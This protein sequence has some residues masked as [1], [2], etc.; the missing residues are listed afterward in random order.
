MQVT[1]LRT[2]ELKKSKSVVTALHQGRSYVPYQVRP[3]TLRRPYLHDRSAAT[4]ANAHM[5]RDTRHARA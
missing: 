4:P 2:N 3:C 1:K 5:R